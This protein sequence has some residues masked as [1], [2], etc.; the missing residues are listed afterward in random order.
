MVARGGVEPPT[1]R[2]SEWR[3]AA[4]S[5]FAVALRPGQGL[6][7]PLGQAANLVSLCRRRAH[8]TAGE[9]EPRADCSWC[10]DGSERSALRHAGHKARTT[11]LG[12]GSP[13]ASWRRHRCR[14]CGVGSGAVM[15][16]ERQ[17]GDD[18]LTTF[19]AGSVGLLI[20]GGLLIW[21]LAALFD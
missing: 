7:G 5:V 3:V 9:S 16:P 13:D 18:C 14:P 8:E 17:R 6:L 15:R 4:N 20:F 10:D 1:F 21:A 2:F 11:P 12:P 19:L